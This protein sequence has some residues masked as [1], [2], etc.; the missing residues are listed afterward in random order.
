M[1]GRVVQTKDPTLYTQVLGNEPERPMPNTPPH[2]N[3]AP[4]QNYLVGRLDLKTG[5]RS[6]DVLRWG[7]IPS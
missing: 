6:V 7:L 1:C 5:E 4:G 2:Y 3:D